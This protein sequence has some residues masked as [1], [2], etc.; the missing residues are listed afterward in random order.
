MI[1]MSV[2]WGVLQHYCLN[3]STFPCLCA[4]GIFLN[5]VRSISYPETPN[6]KSDRLLPLTM[7][8]LLRGPG[9]SQ[10]VRVT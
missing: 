3:L 10:G 5:S 1:S 9:A 6:T 2:F 7:R 4:I 8:G